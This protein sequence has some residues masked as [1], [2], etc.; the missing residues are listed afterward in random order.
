MSFSELVLLSFMC[1]AGVHGKELSVGC[2]LFA[3]GKS[4]L[5]EFSHDVQLPRNSFF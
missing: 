3:A 4:D 1:N 5:S 2:L